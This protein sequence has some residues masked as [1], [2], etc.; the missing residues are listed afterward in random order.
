MTN[1]TRGAGHREAGDRSASLL[2]ADGASLP[3]VLLLDG[4]ESPSV[5]SGRAVRSIKSALSSA[6]M[7]V[8]LATPP[9][10]AGTWCEPGGGIETSRVLVAV[11]GRRPSS[12]LTSTLAMVECPGVLFLLDAPA[13]EEEAATARLFDEIWVPSRAVAEAASTVLDRPARVVGLPGEVHMEHFVGRRHFKVPES[14]FMFLAPVDAAQLQA[15]HSALAAVQAFKA[16]FARRPEYDATLVLRLR[17]DWSSKAIAAIRGEVVGCRH[18]VVVL[19]SS[20]SENE[21]VNLLRCADVVVSLH[22][23]VPFGQELAQA[24]FLGKPVIAT[25][26]GGNL[27]FMSPRNSLLVDPSEA[28]AAAAGRCDVDA[29]I[30]GA[31]RALAKVGDDETFRLS[32]STQARHDLRIRWSDQAVGI[33]YARELQAISKTTVE[34]TQEAR[35]ATTETQ[36]MRSPILPSSRRP[37]FYAEADAPRILFV[38]HDAHRFGAQMVLLDMLRW[39]SESSGL[40]PKVLLLEGG[41]LADEFRAVAKVDLL[42][43]TR[44]DLEPSEVLRAARRLFPEPPDLVYGNTGVAGRYYE[45]LSEMGAPIITHIHELQKSIERFVGLD[46]M[47]EVVAHSC[48]F[49]AVSPPVADNLRVRWSVPDSRVSIVHPH[50][51]PRF[52]G[53][54]FRRRAE[55]RR[56]LGLPLDTVIVWGSGSTDWRKAPDLFV[57]VAATMVKNGHREVRFIW[58]GGDIDAER[59]QIQHLGVADYV[60]FRGPSDD[61]RAYFAAG[62]ILCLPSREDPFPLVCLEAA[63]AGLPVVCFDGAGMP[64]LIRESAGFV[65]PFGDVDEMAAQTARLVGDSALRDALGRKG[66]SLVLARHTTDTQVPQL[67][68]SC[69]SVVRGRPRVSVIMPN[70]NYADYLEKR[71]LSI[72]GQTFTDFEVIILDDGS[73]DNSPELLRAYAGRRNTRILELPTN[74]GSVFRQWLRGLSMATGDLVWIA[75]ADDLCETEFLARLV[76]LFDDPDVVLAYCHS[77]VIDEN[78]AL[79][80]DLDY[81]SDYLGDLSA[82]KWFHAYRNAGTHEV[83]EGLGVRNTIPNVSAVV[84][85]RAAVAGVAD[86]LT[87]YRF[88]GDWLLYLYLASRG[89]FCYEPEG[90]NF[91][92][93]HDR[94][95]VAQTLRAAP[96]VLAEFRGIHE[97]VFENFAVSDELGR[98]MFHFVTETLPTW[99]PGLRTEDIDQYYLSERLR[100][101]RDAVMPSRDRT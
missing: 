24:M 40:R 48:H 59:E 6:G 78:G 25:A 42:K 30:E 73:T 67:L 60:S 1:L 56:M 13:S 87:K 38:S 12:L 16:H 74:G 68:A 96:A 9:D 41:A 23:W 11:A 20:L 92:R 52:D 33:G 77:R 80:E 14:A 18:P 21:E 36:A 43:G 84:F 86:S 69:R 7:R 2:V 50:I 5:P 88:S 93:R 91:H 100:A 22:E 98:K 71:M 57:Q 85:R 76:P 8:I 79:V 4:T 83:E 54:V 37:V 66:R 64:A 97:F 99:I 65:I 101:A 3:E 95:V 29:R 82:T 94:S 31:A 49:V 75:E 53:S 58:L 47:S 62:D 32:I 28:N 51:R 72:Y 34:P 63:E 44:A 55:V 17:G 81:R 15:E 45:A 19:A 39:I 26:R 70:Y 35:P 61:P 10:P 27:D 90:L 46:T 89:M